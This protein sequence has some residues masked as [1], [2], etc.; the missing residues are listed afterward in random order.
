MLPWQW[1]GPDKKPTAPGGLERRSAKAS[2][3]WQSAVALKKEK[4]TQPNMAWH[5]LWHANA[6][7]SLLKLW[8]NM[9]SGNQAT[10]SSKQIA[11]DVVLVVWV[12]VEDVVV[13]IVGVVVV[14]T[15]EVVTVVEVV[16][17]VVVAVVVVEVEL[18]EVA[19]V[20]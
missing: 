5:R 1:K 16:V 6:S 18:V 9:S 15:V 20:V 10:L 13:V 2:V 8:P 17:N 3:K 7:G 12:S 19:V 11:V 4:C 14:V